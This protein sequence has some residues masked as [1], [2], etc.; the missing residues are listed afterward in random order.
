MPDA[1]RCDGS[2]PV[3]NGYATELFPTALRGQATSWASV[4]RVAG[5]VTSLGLGAALLAVTGGLPATATILGLGSVLAIVIYAVWFPDTHG[6]E[7]EDIAGDERFS[8]RAPAD[9]QAFVVDAGARPP[10]FATSASTAAPNA[11]G[12]T[13]S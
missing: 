6:R 7:L 4:A 5:Q 9:D 12:A 3:L 11:S 8:G 10:L 2:F 13:L 1:R